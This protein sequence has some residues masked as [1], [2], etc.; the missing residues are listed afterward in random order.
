[1]ATTTKNVGSFGAQLV[2]AIRSV[3]ICRGCA[4]RPSFVSGGQGQRS[5]LIGSWGCA[6]GTCV[7]TATDE[8]P[9]VT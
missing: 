8:A 9:A 4:S 6:R 3:A 1:M 7:I 2:D 5:A